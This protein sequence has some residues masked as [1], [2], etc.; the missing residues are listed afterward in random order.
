MDISSRKTYVETSAQGALYGVQSFINKFPKTPKATDLVEPVIT[1]RFVPT[2]SD[3]LLYGLGKLA[4]ERN[5]RIQSHLAEARD[6]VNWVEAERNK[7]DIDIFDEVCLS[8]FLCLYIRLA[9]LEYST[10]S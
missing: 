2:C 6:Q 9:T 7:A 1:P 10:T 3:E 4:K 8:H 5:S